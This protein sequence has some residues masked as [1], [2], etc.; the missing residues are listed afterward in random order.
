MKT[1]VKI[2]LILG[3]VL[4]S[5]GYLF[6]GVRG[7]ALALTVMVVIPLMVIQFIANLI[8][9]GIVKALFNMFAIP[10]FLGILV[11]VFGLPSWGNGYGPLAFLVT[12]VPKGLIPW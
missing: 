2:V 4:A 6:M 7:L 8:T 1:I 9:G 3:V 10:I 5:S 12:E 11:L